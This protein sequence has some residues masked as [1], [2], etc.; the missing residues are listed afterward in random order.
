MIYLSYAKA[1]LIVMERLC[2]DLKSEGFDLLTAKDIALNQSR[3]KYDK[4]VI[5]KTKYFFLL[6]SKNSVNKD[7]VFLEG[8]KLDIEIYCKFAP[9]TIVIPISLDG[10]HA[11]NKVFDSLQYVNF[12]NHTNGFTKI[13][14]TLKKS[15][16][17]EAAATSPMKQATIL[18]VKR[19]VVGDKS[20]FGTY[21]SWE[22]IFVGRDC[23]VEKLLSSSKDAFIFGAR[24][25][26]K[27]SLLRYVKKQYE[28]RNLNISAFYISLQGVTSS[29]KFKRKLRNAFL[30][31]KF[32]IDE[33]LL[34]KHTLLDFLEELDIYLTDPIVIMTDEAEEIGQLEKNEPGF[35]NAFRNIVESTEKVRFVMT[36]SPYF[37][38]I[39]SSIDCTCS[40]FLSA[41]DLHTLS[42]LSRDEAYELMRELFINI[43]DE[44]INI[45]DEDMEQI[46]TFTYYQPY[47]IRIFISKLILG[48]GLRSPSKEL[49]LEAY[50]SNAL[51][52]IFPNYLDG[53][54]DKEQ[55]VLFQVKSDK[56][57]FAD[58]N[59][60]RLKA[61]ELY[62]YL[63]SEDGQYQISN[64]FFLYWLNCEYDEKSTDIC[65]QTS[66]ALAKPV[67]KVDF[68][69]HKEN[70]PSQNFSIMATRFQLVYS[71]VG[72]F[73]GLVCIISGVFLFC[74][75]ATGGTS[76]TAK[77]LGA[78]S[79]I[80][81]AAPGV[82]LFIVGLF[83]VFITRFSV[84]RIID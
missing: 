46:L 79:R 34:N 23:L 26:G 74:N 66:I 51:T 37:I 18:G 84:K 62:G 39:A 43:S 12:Q 41:F 20:K 24:R 19:A 21:G 73:L 11:H 6:I 3:N 54:S 33:D 28:E 22:D 77:I 71:L 52:G 1:D 49:A 59:E 68:V 29:D 75:D 16:M 48:D 55:E 38:K 61:L 9:D 72:Q 80:T 8:I 44:V 5:K 81:D 64:W 60:A 56:I 14:K 40:A 70:N 47:L 15:Q 78:E 45:S 7:G 27:T 25:I 65:D 35:M 82:V 32:C 13:M 83:M 63:K 50:S 4:H 10:T 58:K 17:A 2:V 42:V 69:P 67:K 36:A 30:R 53:L 31:E 57:E 76:W